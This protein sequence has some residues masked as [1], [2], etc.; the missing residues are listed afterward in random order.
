M[1]PKFVGILPTSHHLEGRKLFLCFFFE[2]LALL[3]NTK[4]LWK[5]ILIYVINWPYSLLLG[6]PK[7]AVT[8]YA[9]MHL[10]T[11]QM[12][13]YMRLKTIQM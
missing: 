3:T 7:Y 1:Q 11:A 12:L 8:L 6:H 5:V 9:N 13:R 2:L 4:R 10:K